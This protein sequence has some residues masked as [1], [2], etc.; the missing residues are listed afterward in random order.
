V[1]FPKIDSSRLRAFFKNPS[2]RRAATAIFLLV[3][4]ALI[5]QEARS[6]EWQKVGLAA[7]SYAASTL[8]L[9]AALAA[10]SYFIYSCY[11]LLGRYYTGVKL[12][13]SAMMST[14]F[15]SFATNQSLGAL[16]GSVGFRIR[17]Y[18]KLGVEAAQIG[19]IAGLS[20]VTNWLGYAAIAGAVFLFGNISLP[21][22]VDMAP[23]WEIGR[24]IVRSVGAVL[25]LLALAYLGLCSWSRKREFTIRKTKIVL[26]GA[27]LAFAQ[28]GLSVM[29]WPVAASVVYV[30]FQGQVDFV[31]VLAAL[32]LSSIA[33][34]ITHIP[35][36]LGV[37][38]AIF[39]ALLGHRVPTPTILAAL[40]VFRAIYYLAPLL[41]AALM[42]LRIETRSRAEK[43][44]NKSKG[45]SRNRSE[46]AM[47]SRVGPR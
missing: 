44:S 3:V 45:E 22:E 29:H 9:A 47:L 28:L 13:A 5:V 32:L 24:S 30:L 17:I 1:I 42:Y 19:R 2:V 41:I 11:E 12:A 36:G 38:E 16:I 6:I 14:A 26:P 8:V 4:G 34:V 39:I 21:K 25:L 7:K 33:V 18:S 46:R 10:V 23:G 43:P 27:G 37:L 20:I 15:V 31:T 40:L 35:A